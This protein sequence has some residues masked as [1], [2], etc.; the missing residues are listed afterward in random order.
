MLGGRKARQYDHDGLGVLYV[1]VVGRIVL[2]YLSCRYGE[3]PLL[4]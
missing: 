3:H 4:P 1:M 2:E